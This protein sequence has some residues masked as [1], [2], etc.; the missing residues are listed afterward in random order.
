MKCLGDRCARGTLNYRSSYEHPTGA[1][2]DGTSP[3]PSL[4]TNSQKYCY[5]YVTSNSS[6][7]VTLPPSNLLSGLAIN[8]RSEFDDQNTTT[9]V[10]ERTESLGLVNGR[11]F[12]FTAYQGLFKSIMLYLVDFDTVPHNDHPGTS[13][14]AAI[15]NAP[16]SKYLQATFTETS[17]L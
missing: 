9:R 8:W 13:A 14:S 12:I 17:L 15:L 3:E 4:P 10:H 16:T 5:E 11:M 6:A 1:A 7:P 2:V